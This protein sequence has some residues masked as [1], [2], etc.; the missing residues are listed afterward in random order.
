MRL[1]VKSL[2]YAIAMLAILA[3]PAFAGDAAT[4]IFK[5]GQVVNI[6]DGYRIIAD[7]FRARGNSEDN[8]IRLDLNGGDVLISLEEVVVVCRDKCPSVKIQHQLEPKK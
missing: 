4:I 7:A 2:G 5:S 8:I 3:K 1:V 6:E